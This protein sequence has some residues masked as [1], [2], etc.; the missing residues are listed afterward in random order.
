M[1]LRLGTKFTLLLVGVF[2]IGVAGSGMILNGTL[3]RRAED[4]VATRGLLLLE[5]MNSVRTY[6]GTHVNP[7]LQDDLAASD[8]FIRESVPGFSA[9]EVFEI[10]RNDENHEDFFYKEATL[11]PTNPRDQADGFETELVEQFRADN[12]LEELTGFRTLNDL[13]MFYIARP[14]RVTSES[15]L[16]C[17]SDAAS[18]PESMLVTYGDDG[19]FGWELGQIIAAQ[20]VYVPA[21]EVFDNARQAF[22]LIIAIFVSVFGLVLVALNIL[23]RPAVVSPILQLARLAAKVGDDNLAKED[24]NRLSN[25]QVI[26]RKDELGQLARIFGN[27][28]QEVFKRENAL[29]QQLQELR[30][31]VDLAKRT[32]QVSEITETEYFMNLQQQ[33]RNMRRRDRDNTD[34]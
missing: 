18:A 20:M 7:I 26:S 33:A 2:L 17:H 6:T 34:M 30:I 11:N 5:A 31:E 28:A 29:R 10:F 15:C 27:M 9:R 12:D 1:N 22:I 16:A 14:M 24:L 21:D 13:R 3:N 8:Q 23:M 4:E 25:S 19:G 32:T